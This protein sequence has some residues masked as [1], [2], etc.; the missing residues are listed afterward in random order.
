MDAGFDF[1]TPL[2]FGPKAR[3]KNLAISLKFLPK[4]KITGLVPPPDPNLL[5]SPNLK[6][7]CSLSTAEHRCE[8][9][10]F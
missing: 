3:K 7:D 6:C 10:R 8:G 4:K 9:V 1:W 5:I 2:I